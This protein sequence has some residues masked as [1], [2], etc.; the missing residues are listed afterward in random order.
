MDGARGTSTVVSRTTMIY[1]VIVATMCSQS[2]ITIIN[3]GHCEN[4]IKDLA[5][6]DGTT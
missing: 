3:Q 6:R 4:V 2:T 5:D 1:E